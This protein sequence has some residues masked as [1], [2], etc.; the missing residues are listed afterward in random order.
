M[1]TLV[2]FGKY[3][4]DKWFYTQLLSTASSTTMSWVTHLCITGS[5]QQYLK[6]RQIGWSPGA[7]SCQSRMKTE[8]LSLS[9][10]QAVHSAHDDSPPCDT[11]SASSSGQTHWWFESSL[12]YWWVR[13]LHRRGTAAQSLPTAV[14]WFASMFQPWK[15][16]I[17]SIDK[18]YF[19]CD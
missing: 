16:S 10:L 12:L 4:P 7:L 3:H 17:H 13:S 14:K 2:S 15:E 1:N 9:P 8:A 11:Q 6:N 18:M 19:E 5:H